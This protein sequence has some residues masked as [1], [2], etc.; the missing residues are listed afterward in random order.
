MTAP[1]HAPGIH[2]G[3][4]RTDLPPGLS[5]S[6]A[7]DILASPFLYQW[8]RT[9][10]KPPSAAMELGTIVHAL[11]L[12]QPRCW[13]TIDG[14]RGVTERRNA[15]REAGL[16]PVTLDELAD[17]ARIAN[18]V[19]DLPEAADLLTR[20]PLDMREVAAVA[21]DP[22][23]PEDE[24]VWLR[25]FFDA[26]HDGG[27]YALDVKT[28]RAGTL[29]DFG[30]VAVNLNYCVQAAVSH[31]IMEWLGRPIDAFLFVV[32]ESE[33]PW[34]CGVRELD[35]DLLRLGHA[36]L[37]R[38]IATYRECVASGVWPGPPPYQTV[39]APTWALRQEGIA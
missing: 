24:R 3:L 23:V 30:R 35:D 27:N 38:A 22:S 10:R 13:V 12:E 6:A 31:R 4:T 37:D 11:T 8:K 36:R 19:W 25:A 18:A 33:A 28:G 20:C 21:Y 32:V 39:S 14:G 2:P 29:A 17:A 26:Y 5:Y 34:L 1:T 15:A 16:I 9:H 7:K